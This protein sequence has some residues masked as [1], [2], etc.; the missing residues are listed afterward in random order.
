MKKKYFNKIEKYLVIF[1]III[2][3]GFI[4]F[5][6]GYCSHKLP[7]VSNTNKS[8]AAVLS[9][10]LQNSSDLITQKYYYQSAY[11]DEDEKSI[12]L[13]FNIHFKMPFSK[14]R[15]LFTYSGTVSAG[16]DVLKIKVMVDDNKKQI[17]IK[18]PKMK[19]IA[20]EID[21][22]SFNQEFEDNSLFN[23]YDSNDT[24]GLISDLKH[25]MEKA[26]MKDKRFLSEAEANAKKIIE[27][28]I[29]STGKTKGYEI[30]F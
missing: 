12:N 20:N 9:N 11:Y 14:K 1:S 8:V 24:V 28:I 2:L 4:C 18:L 30:V 6:F 27:E 13:P 3:I 17:G 21:M 16:Y 26:A 7:L 23:R 5:I 29:Q 15:T 10:S 25:G 19:I 22:D